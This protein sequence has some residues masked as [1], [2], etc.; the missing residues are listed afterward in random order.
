M[1]AMYGHAIVDELLAIKHQKEYLKRADLE[2][3]IEKYK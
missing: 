3:I 1:Q 2:A